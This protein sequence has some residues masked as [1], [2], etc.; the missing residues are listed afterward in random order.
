[1]S[2]DNKKADFIRRRI[3]TNFKIYKEKIPEYSFVL[4]E[5]KD[6][7]IHLHGIMKIENA[8][9]IKHIL[10]LTCFGS[11]YKNSS[12]NKYIFHYKQSYN[13]G[14]WCAYCLK[15]KFVKNKTICSYTS[16]NLSRAVK[17]EY[18]IMKKGD[19]PVG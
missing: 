1:M 18:N 14:K 5:D 19:N 16:R 6:G 8:E 9:K 3:N 11:D 7:Y 2:K 12:F 15:G 13:A 17:F 10:K 4:E